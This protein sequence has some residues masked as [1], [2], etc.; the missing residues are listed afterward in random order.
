MNLYGDVS[1]RMEY[2]QKLFMDVEVKVD[3]IQALHEVIA[4]LDTEPPVFR[5]VSYESASMQ[6][7]LNELRKNQHT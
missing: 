1:G 2:M 6:I 7:S 4:Y 3:K 5:S